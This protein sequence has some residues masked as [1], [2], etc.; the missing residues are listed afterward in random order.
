MCS[1]HCR[2][3]SFH[4]SCTSSG[5]RKGY[6]NHPCPPLS[7]YWV[8]DYLSMLVLNVGKRVPR[9]SSIRTFGCL[10]DFLVQCFKRFSNWR[11]FVEI[12]AT[13]IARFIGPRWGPSG[14]DRT[15]V[16]PMLAPWTCY[17]G[18]FGQYIRYQTR[19]YRWQYSIFPKS[20]I[21][22]MICHTSKRIMMAS[23]I[24]MLLSG[25]DSP[26]I[27]LKPQA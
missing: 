1:V 7:L 8:H 17:F 18:R 3:H 6:C 16:G 12:P 5:G 13:L 27:Q 4:V 25:I 20:V 9:C 14:A 2:S 19:A 10:L 21:T 24:F 15:Q 23:N 22:F 11:I 26:P